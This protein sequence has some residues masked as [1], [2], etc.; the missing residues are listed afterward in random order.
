MSAP[1]RIGIVGATGLLGREVIE[2]LEA[3][4]FPVLELRAFAGDRSL[5]ED[6]EFQGDVVP[7]RV[8][9]DDWTGLDVVVLCTPAAAALDLVRAAL[10]AEVPC[11]DC[12]GALVGSAEVPLAI[13]DLGARDDLAAAPL[14][15]AAPGPALVW[16]PVLAA[17]Q[18]EAGLRRVTGSVLHSASSAGRAGVAALS[19]QTL[20]LLNQREWHGVD[21][22]AGPRAFDC[23]AHAVHDDEDK[24]RAAPIEAQL[25][26]ILRRLLGPDVAIAVTSVHVP[27]FAGQGV[28]LSVETERPLG[29]ERAAE[30]LAAAPG[31]EVWG[32]GEGP[33]TRDSVGRGEVIVGRL[34][35]DPTAPPGHGVLLWLVG[36][37]V[38]L[39]AANVVKL[40]RA[41]FAGA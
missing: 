24:E 1:L 33:S 18:R 34:R 41:R 19:E 31:V 2:V 3:E 7:V 40:L 35:T 39:A 4:R 12:S 32:E 16:A 20:A 37:P 6:V 15:S 30:V 5:G 28:T 21:V 36:D 11:I 22:P 23:H 26:A 27:T 13:A 25:V 17:L 14:I 38:R 29:P 10:H 9:D 8:D